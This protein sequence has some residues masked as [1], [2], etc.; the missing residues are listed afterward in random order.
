MSKEEIHVALACDDAYA[1]YCAETIVSILLNT[2]DENV[3]YN[4]YIMQ[5]G[6]L[7]ENRRRIGKLKNTV[8][9]CSIEFL[10]LYSNG[11]AAFR[12]PIFYRLRLASLLPKL[13]K[14]IYTDCDVTFLSGLEDIWHEDIGEHYSGNCVDWSRD[15]ERI[16][17]YFSE[18]CGVS[19]H[20]YPFGD[21][22]IYFNSGFMVMNLAK[23]REDGIE[24]KSVEC[25]EKY[26]NLI[27]GDQDIINLV[28]YGKI[29]P[30]SFGWSFLISYYTTKRSRIR[31]KNSSL[32]ADLRD[33]AKNPRMIHFIANKKPTNIYK[34]I[35][36]I[37]SYRIVNRYKKI[38]WKY[39]AHTDWQNERT[40]KTIYKFPLGF[41]NHWKI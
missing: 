16:T 2:R 24:D 39:V 13:D 34:S 29:K 8:K 15:R 4:F 32:L 6:L 38:F 41:L 3:F 36:H 12:N 20:D 22:E 27:Y 23:I 31:I 9:D 25:I 10:D 40:Y 35:F 37:P 28:Y 5:D 21:R 19:E 30:I 17:K 33:S 11:V 26:P 7:E 14:V 18:T 1:F